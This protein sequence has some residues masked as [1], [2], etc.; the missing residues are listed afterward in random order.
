MRNRKGFSLVE[1][2]VVMVL[3]VL[4]MSAIYMMIMYYKDVS[5]TEQ[6]RIRQTQESRYMLSVFSSE[7]KNA[8]AVMT[9]AN[10]GSF[11]ATPPFFNGIYPLNNT[12]YPDGVILA[13]ADPNAVSKLTA[14]ADPSTS[15]FELQVS[16]VVGNPG[17]SE[18]DQ[19]ILIGPDG[20]YVFRVATGGVSATSLTLTDAPIYYSGLLNTTHY[21][22][23]EPAAGA[24]NEVI[25]PV[26]SPVMRLADFGIYLIE[27]RFDD[28][29]GRNVRDLVRV[30]DCAGQANVLTSTNPNIVK[31]V[32]AENIWDLQLAYTAYPNFPNV[33]P[34]NDFFTSGGSS[35]LADLLNDIRS[36]AF[37][38]VTVSVV[39]LTDDYP[40][41]GVVSYSL[42]QLA[43]HAPSASNNLTGKFTYK[44]YS[45]MIQ[46]RNYNI[47][48]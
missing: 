7:L 9:L 4:I 2:M 3:M 13:S 31:G 29:K 16:S 18:G 32:I 27:E 15:P 17:W 19:G 21:I 47:N 33:A 22:D 14:E 37:K 45:F 11:L 8:G 30:S 26:N 24:G 36:K 48:L 43:D 34:K 1:G 10:T 35:V 28:A 25:Y 41:K 38:E 23:T 12:N 20:F 6:A 40:G 46:P 44:T 39:A 5:G 42:P